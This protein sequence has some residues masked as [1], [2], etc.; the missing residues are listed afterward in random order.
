MILIS[1]RSALG[2]VVLPDVVVVL[3][4]V[5]VVVVAATPKTTPKVTATAITAT[6]TRTPA[7]ILYH[8]EGIRVDRLAKETEMSG[9]SI[10]R[11]GKE[12]RHTKHFLPMA[13]CSHLN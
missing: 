2:Q 12:T 4:V 3:V 9:G 10:L 6:A 11:S 7:P 5:V 8:N 13:L 1:S